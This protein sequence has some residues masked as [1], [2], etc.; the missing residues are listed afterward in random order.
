MCVNVE[1]SKQK[2]RR[3][4]ARTF[5]SVI[6]L[7]GVCKNNTY[8]DSLPFK[9]CVTL[10]ALYGIGWGGLKNK[11]DGGKMEAVLSTHI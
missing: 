6:E 8:R 7:I 10:A 5:F 11:G 9:Q 4:W 2:S 3:I 1:A